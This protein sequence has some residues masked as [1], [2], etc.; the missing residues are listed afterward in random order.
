MNIKKSFLVGT[1][2]L[3][4][5]LVIVYLGLYFASKKSTDTANDVVASSDET[6]NWKTY[7]NEKYGF[8]LK[9]PVEWGEMIK[10]SN[11]RE[12]NCGPSSNDHTVG[13]EYSIPE[14]SV[15]LACEN[16]RFETNDLINTVP[17]KI[18]IGGRESYLYEYTSATN[19]TNKEIFIPLYDGI[20]IY[21]FHSYKPTPQY[22]PLSATELNNIISS[23]KFTQ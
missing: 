9:Y 4:T 19:Y 12:L 8:E 22:T 21:L 1:I 20:Y 11:L 18:I 2:I 16:Y 6:A 3:I 14:L 7:R 15:G 10:S 17:K 13:L 23:F 5:L